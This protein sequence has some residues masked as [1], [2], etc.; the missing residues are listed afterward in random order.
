[1]ANHFA[2]Q[3]VCSC[4]YDVPYFR[5]YPRLLAEF[6]ANRVY[7][8]SYDKSR[9][10]PTTGNDASS[11]YSSLNVSQELKD[12]TTQ[13]WSTFATYPYYGHESNVA[14]GH[15]SP[16]YVSYSRPEEVISIKKPPTREMT[17]TLKAWLNEHKKNPYPTKAEKIMLAIITKMTLTQVS[18]WFANAR[19]RLKKDNKV[20]W[21]VK[22]KPGDVDNDDDDEQRDDDIKDED[23]NRITDNN[24]NSNTMESD[25]RFC[26]SYPALQQTVESKLKPASESDLSPSVSPKPSEASSKPRIWSLADTA[27]SPDSSISDHGITSHFRPVQLRHMPSSY[28]WTESAFERVPALGLASPMPFLQERDFAYPNASLQSNASDTNLH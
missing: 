6:R 8:T 18:T 11:F 21:E 3:D 5:D 19:R 20:T 23:T 1:M 25:A 17:A 9:M 24:G 4:T 7:D 10:L 22:N 13:A 28:S 12:T 16:S 26:P 27:M 15:Y 2:S 14:L